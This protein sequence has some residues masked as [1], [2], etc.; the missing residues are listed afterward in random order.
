MVVH[1][2]P[3]VSRNL[4]FVVYIHKFTFP[5]NPNCIIHLWVIVYGRMLLASFHKPG[6]SCLSFFS[7]E[8][9][10]IKYTAL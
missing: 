8:T 10:I 6:S 1:T 5:Y 4:C 3:K 2:S 9:D 7:K